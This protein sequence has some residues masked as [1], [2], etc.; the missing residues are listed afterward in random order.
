VSELVKEK[1]IIKGG[2]YQ[3]KL[4]DCSIDKKGK[5]TGASPTVGFR[6]V[7]EIKYVE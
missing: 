4:K 5:Y 1:G 6:T 2:S 3:D 7:C